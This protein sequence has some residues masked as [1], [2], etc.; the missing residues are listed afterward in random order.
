[1]EQKEIV[2]AVKYARPPKIQKYRTTLELKQGDKVVVDTI[3]GMEIGEVIEVLETLPNQDMKRVMRIATEKDIEANEENMA[4]AKPYI[5]KAKERIAEL[6]L[7]MKLICAEFT[8][9]F[10]KVILTFTSEGRVD[11]RELVKRLAGDFRMKIELRQ[12]G[13]RDA[14]QALGAIGFC[15]KEC[16]CM[17]KT[18]GLCHVS[19]KMAKTQGLP[20]NPNAVSGLCGKLLCCLAYENNQYKEILSQM[21]KVNSEVETPEGKGRVVYNDIF[22]NM[23]TVRVDTATK[24]FKPEDLKIKY[25]AENSKA[26]EEK[27][28]EKE[29]EDDE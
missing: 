29:V 3:R 23:V 9:D 22:E 8:L 12:I 17:K 1:M 5:V 25:Y 19:I 6:G 10:T 14:V 11:F 21:P 2:V 13:P 27:S 20:L 4:K 18:G 15:G 16:C 28:E 26:Q 24:K 7:D